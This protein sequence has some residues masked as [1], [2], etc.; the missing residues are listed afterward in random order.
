MTKARAGSNSG[1]A[2]VVCSEAGNNS[3]QQGRG[4]SSVVSEQEEK[5]ELEVWRVMALEGTQQ[6][7]PWLVITS[8]TT[9]EL[10]QPGV[11]ALNVCKTME[12]VKLYHRCT[13]CTVRQHSKYCTPHTITIE[14]DLWC[15]FC[16][17]DKNT[18]QA[19]GK[20]IVHTSELSMMAVFRELGLDTLVSWQVQAEFWRGCID[21]WVRGFN[22]FVQAD[23]SV[24][25]YGGWGEKRAD[26]FKRDVRFCTAAY[27]ENVQVIR[28]HPDYVNRSM[29]LPAALSLRSTAGLVVLSPS[30]GGRVLQD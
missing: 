17:F 1:R 2:C 16:M 24:H 28:V 13:G 9:A 12:G 5:P 3:R 18:W 29:Y 22:K 30:Y 8:C 10:Q 7:N 20:G 23:G 4:S 27:K 6:L 11:E 15:P 21:F 14:S 19:V 26:L 25:L